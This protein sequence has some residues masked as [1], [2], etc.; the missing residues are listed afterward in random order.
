MFELLK[1]KNANQTDQAEAGK[2]LK[3]IVEQAEKM[4]R[5]VQDKFTRIQGISFI[6][7]LL[8]DHHDREVTS[9]SYATVVV[10]A[11]VQNNADLCVF[12]V[13]ELE[14]KINQLTKKKEDKAAEVSTLLETADSLRKEIAKRAEEYTT[15]TS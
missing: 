13:S 5:E 8:N 9:V 11:I 1:Q 4:K 10:C 6:F 2:R 3:D 14:E 12:C 15:C 7:S